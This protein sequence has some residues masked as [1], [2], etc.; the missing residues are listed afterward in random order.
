MNN[1]TMHLR[2]LDEVKRWIAECERHITEQ[3][4][5]IVTLGPNGDDIAQAEQLLQIFQ[6]TQAQHIIHRDMILKELD[7]WLP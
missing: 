7:K 3:E 6:Q 1:R 2:H 5:R 4:Q